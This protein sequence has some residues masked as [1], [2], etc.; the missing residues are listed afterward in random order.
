MNLSSSSLIGDFALFITILIVCCVSFFLVNK[1]LINHVWKRTIMG[2]LFLLLCNSLFYICSAY[3][4]LPKDFILSVV[5]NFCLAPLLYV[6]LFDAID[7]QDQAVLY[8]QKY[9]PLTFTLYWSLLY[10]VLYISFFL[11]TYQWCIVYLNQIYLFTGAALCLIYACYVSYLCFSYYIE[12]QKKIIIFGYAFILYCLSIYCFYYAIMIQ[13]EQ[14]ALLMYGHLFLSLLLAYYVVKYLIS[15]D[16]E[17]LH[18]NQNNT[19][20]SSI[21]HR[22][23]GNLSQSVIKGTQSYEQDMQKFRVIISRHLIDEQLFLDP[24]IDLS[25]LA[26]KTKISK[27]HLQQFFKKSTASGF[28]EYVNRLRIEYCLTVLKQDNRIRDLQSWGSAC[29]F[30]SKSTFYRSFVQVKGFP[31]TNILKN[32]LKNKHI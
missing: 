18:N 1:V 12:E 4:L 7:S 8:Q 11:S 2:I 24:N 6:L 20:I 30:K 32:H 25:L 14:G 19:L 28:N 13:M 27:P 26:L 10:L 9:S 16:F 31:P 23:T 15:H 21:A 29:G 22:A 3:F 5:L 17:L